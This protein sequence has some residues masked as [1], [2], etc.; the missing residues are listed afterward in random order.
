[1]LASLE[2]EM[3]P[4]AR[5]S[6]A[7]PPLRVRPRTRWGSISAGTTSLVLLYSKGGAL[8][9]RTSVPSSDVWFVLAFHSQVVS[10]KY[11]DQ[12]GETFSNGRGGQLVEMSSDFEKRCLS[13]SRDGEN[14]R[15]RTAARE[16]EKERD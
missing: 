6:A 3:D 14:D 15:K 16:R 9:F 5:A 4:G 1:M 10:A 12:G 2:D 13:L 11:T 7:V 8:A